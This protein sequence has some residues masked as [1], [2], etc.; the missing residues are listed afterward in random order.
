MLIIMYNIFSR[1][2]LVIFFIFGLILFLFA[3][4]Q[5]TL[6]FRTEQECQASECKT[7]DYMPPVWVCLDPQPPA[8][9]GPGTIQNPLAPKLSPASPDQAISQFSS[10]LQAMIGILIVAAAV[11]FFFMFL[12]G[13]IKWITSSG[14]KAQIE[15]ARATIMNALIGLV[16]AL[17]LF[18]II[19]L[20]ETIF[21]FDILQI[22][23]GALKIE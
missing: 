17:S 16:I 1:A 10:L 9:P 4:A 23:I 14:D 2:Y 20:I 13:A 21:G 6:A 12:I 11:V 19:K 7:C 3:A 5:P 8:P 22:N 18:A 15:S